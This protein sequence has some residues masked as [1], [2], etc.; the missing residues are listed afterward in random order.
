MSACVTKR[1]ALALLA[2]D[3]LDA[4]EAATLRMHVAKCAG[5]REY[6]REIAQTTSRLQ[7]AVAPASV[8]PSP[9]FLQLVRSAVPKEQPRSGAFW[10][11]LLP[12]TAAAIFLLVIFPRGR[13]DRPAVSLPRVVPTI[14]RNP[15]D[16][17]PTLLNYQI[18]ANQSSDTLDVVLNEQARTAE[19]SGRVYRAGN[20]GA[21]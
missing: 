15:H 11:W 21:E 8:E 12:A 20:W 13:L 7:Q 10:R 18:A 4:R 3:A 19:N 14:A 17:S 16:F 6:L 2:I 1:K 5:C 9:Y